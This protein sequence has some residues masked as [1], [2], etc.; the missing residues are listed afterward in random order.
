MKPRTTFLTLLLFAEL[1]LAATAGLFE[2]ELVRRLLML[3]ALLLPLLLLRYA[4]GGTTFP[5]FFPPRRGAYLLVGLLPAFVLVTA[6]VAA[7]TALVGKALSL[8]LD[9]AV[10]TSPFAL[11]LLVDAALP[12]LAEELFCRG[13]LFAVLR[14]MGRRAAVLGSALL[15]ALMHASPAQIPYALAAGLMLGMLLELSGGLLLPILFHFANN[16]ASLVMHFFLPTGTVF[17]LLSALAVCG[18]AVVVPTVRRAVP[19][20]P[21]HEEHPY[22]FMR[23]LFLSPL[24]LWLAIILTL[25]LL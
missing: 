6:S 8:P 1:A 21:V 3:P 24:L 11:A 12:A 4:P 19:A 7:L 5:R 2:G 25:T 22:A 13:A 17:L 15:F 18:L 16:L 20:P 23:E 10:P 14:P 9:G